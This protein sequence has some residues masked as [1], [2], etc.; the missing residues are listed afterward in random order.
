MTVGPRMP[1]CSPCRGCPIRRAL[2]SVASRSSERCAAVRCRRRTLQR[3]CRGSVRVPVQPRAGWKA[4]TGR[5]GQGKPRLSEVI[6]AHGESRQL[7]RVPK[8]ERSSMPIGKRREGRR[9][10]LQE[11]PDSQGRI[12]VLAPRKRGFADGRSCRALSVEAA[13]PPGKSLRLAVDAPLLALA[14]RLIR[15]T[16][17]LRALAGLRGVLLLLL[18]VGDDGLVVLPLPMKWPPRPPMA[19]PARQPFSFLPRAMT[20]M[21]VPSRMAMAPVA[22]R[23]FFMA[24]PFLVSREH[25]PPVCRASEAAPPRA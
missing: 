24:D 11:N 16:R 20:L 25:R 12:G 10:A 21:G 8:S 7:R 6:C 22:R 13:P 9:K 5:T 19:P 1:P 15:I 4:P 23:A 14:A 3:P 2:W 17:G 18:V